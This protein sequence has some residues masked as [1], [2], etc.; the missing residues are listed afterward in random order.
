MN[1][2]STNGGGTAAPELAALFAAV[3][4]SLPYTQ[5][6][7]AW[8]AFKPQVDALIAG[9]GQE[10]PT[11]RPTNALLEALI[12]RVAGLLPEVAALHDKHFKSPETEAQEAIYNYY[13]DEHLPGLDG[14][15]G[16]WE[17]CGAIG[18][19]VWGAQLI[20]ADSAD[21][22]SAEAEVAL[23][24]G[25]VYIES[26]GGPARELLLL[27]AFLLARENEGRREAEAGP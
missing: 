27:A 17:N 16:N 8:Q 20:T 6:L 25:R 22:R 19:L 26:R 15:A 12:A 10:E 7:A 24:L 21:E 13:T 2:Q 1:E 18:S 9:Y 3:L 5:A 4:P 11:E 23:K 14:A